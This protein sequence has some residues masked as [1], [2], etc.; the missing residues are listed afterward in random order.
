MKDES[1]PLPSSDPGQSRDEIVAEI[2][3]HLAAAEADLVQRGSAPDE[4]RAAARRKFGDIEKIH[5]TCY[6]IQ[7]GETIMLRWTLVSLTAVLC[8]LLGLSV[9]GNW[10]TQSQLADEMG[11][12]SAELKAMAVAKQTPPAVPLPPEI[13]GVIYAGSKD[14]PAI[15]A[16]VTILLANGSVVRKTNTD[17]NGI[18]RSGPLEPGDYCV[19][20]SITGEPPLQSGWLAQSEPVFLHNHSGTVLKDLD[21]VYHSGGIRIV[22]NRNLPEV[23][24][25]G[26]YLIASRLWAFVVPPRR[27]NYLWT[28]Y[29]KMPAEWPVYFAPAVWGKD[30]SNSQSLTE[31]ENNFVSVTSVSLQLQSGTAAE[32]REHTSSVPARFPVGATEIELQLSLTVLPIDKDGNVV[33]SKSVVKELPELSNT[34]PPNSIYAIP[35]SKLDNELSWRII[36]NGQPWMEKLAGGPWDAWGELQKR[37]F[38]VRPPREKLEIRENQFTTL[39]IEIPEGIET[40]IQKAVDETTD[41]QAF[42]D[43]IAQGLLKRPVKIIAT[44][45]EPMNK[46]PA[47][48]SP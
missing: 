13:T 22:L 43:L 17:E 27:R 48:A 33:L 9:L 6:W 12:L 44:A 29:Q 36:S 15:A 28:P 45:H 8:I 46:K 35:W 19:T 42:A 4:A 1:L 5:Q 38:P 40:E 20:S 34:V 25:D 14:K 16:P 47:A 18:Y 21:V 23:R 10:R 41:A 31:S 32:V 26:H 37:G 30:L 3:D 7:N 39:Q 2:A 24:K 11:K